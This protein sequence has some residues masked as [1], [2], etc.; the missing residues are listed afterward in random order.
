MMDMRRRRFVAGG[1]VLATTW[2]ACTF[3]TKVSDNGEMVDAYVPDAGPCMEADTYECAGDELRHCV[4][5]GKPPV[6]DTCF[7][8]CRTDGVGPHCGEVMPK[9]GGATIMD[10][11]GLDSLGDIVISAPTTIDGTAGTITNVTTGFTRELRAT[12]K[13]AVFRMKSLTINAPVKLTGSAAI[14]FVTE[15][16][17][18]VNAIVDAKGPCGE[19]DAAITPGPG[20]FA[21]GLDATDNGD[22]GSGGGRVGAGSAG[23]G[24]GGH[25]GNGGAGGKRATQDGGLGGMPIGDEVITF[26]AGGGGGGAT[27][28]AGGHARGGGGGGAV[29]LVSNTKIVLMSGGIDAGGCGGY[30]G[31][32]GGDDGGGGGGAGG[33]ILLEAPTIEGPGSLAVNGGGGGAGDD[34]SPAEPV[35][36][37]ATLDRLFAA[38]AL[39]NGA[40][41]GGGSGAAAAVFIGTKGV[42]QGTHA[43]GG[44]G[45][46]GRI[47][48]NTRTGNVAATG[49]M[50]PAL[51]DPNSTCTAGSADV[52]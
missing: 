7:W 52:R 26:L 51:N 11:R 4:E 48:L 12:D 37:K 5:V 1:I 3:S 20:G 16:P 47:R 28:G 23:G 22:G 40:G 33:A 42:D 38:G 14:A 17:I 25:G 18:V 9:G 2:V 15:G 49:I 41:G 44:G 34:Q 29:Q 50:S 32:G 8:G 6:P 24:G 46:I 27:A 21:G 39:G 36:K 31:Q 19:N 43:G 45:G 10:T 13:I 30:S 35:G